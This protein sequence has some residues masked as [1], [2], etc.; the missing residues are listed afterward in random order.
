MDENISQPQDAPPVQ[1]SSTLPPPPGLPPIIP[2]AAAAPQPPR[3]S[4]RGWKIFAFILLGLLVISLLANLGSITSRFVGAGHRV[5]SMAGPRI[6]EVLA[7]DNDSDHKVAVVRIEGIITSQATEGDYSMGD[8]VKAQLEAAAKDRRVKAVVLKVDS[9]G[10]EVLASDEI[11]RLVADFQKKT[12]KPVIAS[13]GSL[14]ASGGYYV[15]APCRWIVANELTITGS[16]GVIIG[17]WNY[18][19][20]MNK[21][22]LRPEIYK[23]GR[24]K[25]MLSGS[26][27]ASE[28]PAEE[29]QMVQGLV[30]EVYTK[31][32]D[33]VSSGRE[34]AFQ[35]NQKGSQKSKR[36]A[37]DWIEHADGRVFTGVE[38]LRLGFVDELGNFEDALRRAESLAGIETADVIE[39]QQHFDFSDIFRMFGKAE[40]PVV[41]VDLG[42]ESP[43]LKAGCPYFLFTPSGN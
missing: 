18:R 16:I 1:P 40:A 7:E 38:A 14:A 25:D 26:R 35:S 22:G 19:G 3:K 12:R 36:L 27:E 30:D 33:V 34:A 23:S 41:K 9:P 37:E 4:G 29:R 43:K 24:F 21:V 8:M 42:V 20:L 6:S 5:E 17:G 39:Y 32:K 2:R 31:F 15:S 13:M 11:Y 10:G 28:I